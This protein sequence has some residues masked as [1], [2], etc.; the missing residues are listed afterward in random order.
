VSE[1]VEIRPGS[2]IGRVSLG[3]S[4]ANVRGFLG[5]PTTTEE[6]GDGLEWTYD[7]QEIAV[8][9]ENERVVSIDA[10]GDAIHVCDTSIGGKDRTEIADMLDA[11]GWGQPRI[12]VATDG[13]AEFW[14]YANGVEIT[15]YDERFDNLTVEAP[16]R[17]KKPI[18]SP[19]AK[20]VEERDYRPRRLAFWATFCL[21]ICAAWLYIAAQ[22]RAMNA[23]IRTWPRHKARITRIRPDESRY[24]VTL[25]HEVD[26]ETRE[27]IDTIDDAQFYRVGDVVTVRYAPAWRNVRIES[28]IRD[29]SGKVVF[30]AMCGILALALYVWLAV[31]M[32]GRRKIS[33]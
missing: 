32:F 1:P 9:F 15:F 8:T 7:K 4:L 6:T 26:G 14:R 2:G 22:N 24:D 13:R 33:P 29:P 25:S 21:I 12:E 28:E 20:Y 3:A 23:R 17:T 27:D 5:V 19:P 30:G 16:G 18:E 31:V 11:C 10:Y